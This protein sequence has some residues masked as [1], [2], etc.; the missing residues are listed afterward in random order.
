[1]D[2]IKRILA[3]VRFLD[4][5]GDLSITNIC[6]IIMIYKI[7]MKEVVSVNEMIALLSVLGT[8][9]FKRYTQRKG[10]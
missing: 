9:Q 10:K 1:M 8:Y 6:A 7:F 5:N 2:R 4:E 3:F